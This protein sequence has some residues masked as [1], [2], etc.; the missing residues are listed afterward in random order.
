[1]QAIWGS[2]EEELVPSPCSV[3]Y[4][5]AHPPHP[6]CSLQE[7]LWSKLG[8]AGFQ[9]AVTPTPWKARDEVAT[10]PLPVLGKG[11]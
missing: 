4:P 3:S 6:S 7:L 1:M 5:E 9:G 10:Q 2:C 11:K 8:A